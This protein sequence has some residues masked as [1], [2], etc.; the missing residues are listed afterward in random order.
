MRSKA[1]KVIQIVLASVAGFV[2][3]L[4]CGTLAYRAYRQH[5]NASASAIGTPKGIDEAMFVPICRIEQWVTIRGQDRLNPVLLV[6]D[7]GPGAAGS[8]FV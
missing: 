8:V 1:W 6:L 4:L 3:V 2:V 7:G 5:Q